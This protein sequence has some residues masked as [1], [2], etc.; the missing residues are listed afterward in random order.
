[1][2]ACRRFWLVLQL[3]LRQLRDLQP[4]T[5]HVSHRITI[6]SRRP[7]TRTTRRARAARLLRRAAHCTRLTRLLNHCATAERPSGWLLGSAV[8]A[9]PH[10]GPTHSLARLSPSF[11]PRTLPHPRTKPTQHAQPTSSAH[12]ISRAPHTGIRSLSNHQTRPRFTTT[13]TLCQHGHSRP[14]MCGE[15]TCRPPTLMAFASHGRAPWHDMA[16]T[17]S[18]LAD[19]DSLFGLMA[20]HGCSLRR[21]RITALIALHRTALS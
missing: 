7:A 9:P 17:P 11:T 15:V 8:A 6:S 18:S 19:A 20:A 13:A 21:R 5:P 12:R 2:K 4:G 10:G 1:M 14:V 16:D 3:F